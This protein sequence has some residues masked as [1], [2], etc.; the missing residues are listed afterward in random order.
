MTSDEQFIFENAAADDDLDLLLATHRCADCA[1]FAFLLVETSDG[2]LWLC[3]GCADERE[4]EER[5]A[6]THGAE[7][8]RAA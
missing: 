3:S 5:D 4:G 8:A 2:A 7:A 1:E 6:R